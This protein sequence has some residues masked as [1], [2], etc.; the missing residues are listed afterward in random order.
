MAMSFGADEFLLEISHRFGED[1]QFKPI[2]FI[3]IKNNLTNK[4]AAKCKD[5][6]LLYISAEGYISPCCWIVSYYTLH[7]TEFW[8]NKDQWS[9]SNTTLDDFLQKDLLNTF[10]KKTED[11]YN[12]AYTVCQT[13]CNANT[14]SINEYI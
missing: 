4:I 5:N 7:T 2:K 13:N 14:K 9:I 10:I 8:K 3:D 12:D 6:K 1:D 11:N